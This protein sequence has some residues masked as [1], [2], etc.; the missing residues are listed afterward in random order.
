MPMYE[1]D[2]LAEIARGDVDAYDLLVENDPK[3]SFET[4]F[5]RVDTLLVNLL[6]DVREQFPDACYYTAGGGFNLML[7]NSHS[8]KEK[9]QQQLIALGGQAQIGDGDF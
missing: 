8:Y 9:S 6:R 3:G 5:K 7:G 2:C 1:A 4:R